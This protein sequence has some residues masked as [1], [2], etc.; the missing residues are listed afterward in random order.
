MGRLAPGSVFA[1]YRVEALLGKGGMGAVYRAR[2][3]R[4][5]R[6]VALKVIA[7]PVADDPLIRE[8]FRREACS[9]A[10]IEHPNVVPVFEADAHDGR[11]FLA[12][13]LIDGVDL[14]T[15]IRR[16]RRLEA[17]R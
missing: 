15:L 11:L 1:G 14:A 12:M 2:D 4:L 5:E 3:L 16:E 8:R 13:R 17:E 10:A 9:A 7:E 6:S